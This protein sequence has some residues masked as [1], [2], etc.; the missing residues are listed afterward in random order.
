[1]SRFYYTQKHLFEKVEVRHLRRV[2]MTGDAE[3]I[4]VVG[5]TIHSGGRTALRTNSFRYIFL[6]V[7]YRVYMAVGE[8]Y[9][10]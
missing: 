3:N 10:P 2:G 9:I 6:F 7:L 1:M 8:L 4:V 5:H